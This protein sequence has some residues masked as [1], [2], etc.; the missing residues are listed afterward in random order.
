MPNG[1]MSNGIEPARHNSISFEGVFANRSYQEVPLSLS[2]VQG[3]SGMPPRDTSEIHPEGPSGILV[4]GPSK[5]S[6]RVPPE[7]PSGVSLGTSP[8]VSSGRLIRNFWNLLKF[9]LELLR[10]ASRKM[11]FRSSY[12]GIAPQVPSVISPRIRSGI[13]LKAPGEFRDA[14]MCFIRNSFRNSLS[15]FNRSLFRYPSRSSF[16]R[17]HKWQLEIHQESREK[18]LQEFL[19]GFLL[20]YH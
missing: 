10:D 5:I 19:Q 2:K 9:L 12:T 20:K 11:F 4:G 6:L 7:V 1:F 18:F 13:S 15:Y 17:I 14:S 3:N 16:R 8:G